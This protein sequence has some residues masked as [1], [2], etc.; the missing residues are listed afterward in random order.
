MI[1]VILLAAG[2]S[3]RFRASGG[4]NKL[5]N[6]WGDGPMYRTAL[7]RWKTA[8]SGR[9]DGGAV[10]VVSR[11][12]EILAAAGQY[13]MIPVYSPE[14]FRGI[15]WSIRSG[16]LAAKEET[17][18]R[19][20]RSAE[21]YVFAVADQPMLRTDTMERFLDK[22]KESVF[23]CLAWEETL[24]NPVAFPEKAVGELLQL[25]GDSGGKKVLRRHLEECTV[26]FAA[27]GEELRDI[28][29]LEQLREARSGSLS[30][31]FNTL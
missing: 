28:D 6:R 22:A 16:L 5:L 17:L 10:Y 4:G 20:G 18:A 31:N 24:G 21:H 7:E 9:L 23:A 12:E 3:Q 2:N 14:S 1:D 26:V 13:D 27:S 11:E 29:T 25:E 15:S 30:K 8:A 19:T